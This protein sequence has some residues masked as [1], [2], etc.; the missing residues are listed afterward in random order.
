M[1]LARRIDEVSHC[2]GQRVVNLQ[3]LRMIDRM[4]VDANLAFVTVPPLRDI[5]QDALG[6]H[7]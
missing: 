2:Y 3:N 4:D 6:F 1:Q 7:D 5:D